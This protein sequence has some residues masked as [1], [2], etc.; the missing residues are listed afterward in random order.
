M[1]TYSA[2]LRCPLPPPALMNT[3]YNVERRVRIFFQ[4]EEKKDFW[5]CFWALLSASDKPITLLS[6]STNFEQS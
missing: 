5:G 2:F 6:L 4:G 1:F 3:T